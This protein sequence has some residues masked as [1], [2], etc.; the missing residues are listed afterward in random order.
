MHEEAMAFLEGV[1]VRPDLVFVSALVDEGTKVI[2]WRDGA[3]AHFMIDWPTTSLT[4]CADPLALYSMGPEGDIHVFAPG[5][6]RRETIAGPDRHGPLRAM[7]MI[8]GINYAVGMQ[9]QVFR[10]HDSGA[11]EPLGASILNTDGILGFNCLDGYSQQE[12]Y[13]AGMAG[14][15]WCFDGQQWQ[16][17]AT[18]GTLVLHRMVCAGDGLVYIVGQGGLILA[19]RHAQWRV[20]DTGEQRQDLWGCAWFDGHLYVASNRGVYRWTG[21]ALSPCDIG[22]SGLGCASF[23]MAGHGMLWSIGQRHVAYSRDGERWTGVTND[24]AAC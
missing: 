17:L 12:I 23:L 20:L 10:R 2:R 1:I 7:R 6:R 3:C 18:P 13:A 15:V 21:T 14:E 16:R 5:G 8:E 19:G 24:A 9:R 11:W 22:A 4:A